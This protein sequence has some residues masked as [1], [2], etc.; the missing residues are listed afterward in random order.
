M[1]AAAPLAVPTRHP[2]PRYTYVAR[3]VVEE[4]R[5]AI[6]VSAPPAPAKIR[7]TGL[8]LRG[9]SPDILSPLDKVARRSHRGVRFSFRTTIASTH[10]TPRVRGRGRH[11]YHQ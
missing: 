3:R 11:G 2:Y 6:A 4:S 1:C 5:C 9:R 8:G 10:A 7:V